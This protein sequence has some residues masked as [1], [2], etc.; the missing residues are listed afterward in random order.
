MNKKRN[1][2]DIPS[3]EGLS[4]D[5]EHQSEH[6]KDRR[7]S[8]RISM[9]AL[10]KLFATEELLL[11]VF[12]PGQILTACMSD[13]SEGGLSLS[14]KDNTGAAQRTPGFILAMVC[15]AAAVQ[16]TLKGTTEVLDP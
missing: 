15:P 3:L 2:D 13:L 6:T 10:A 8:V 16:T 5:W 9:K 7:S 14:R 11:K 4:V 12:A 1:G